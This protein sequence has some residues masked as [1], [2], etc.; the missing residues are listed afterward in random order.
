MRDLVRRLRG[1]HPIGPIVNG[2]PRYG[3]R[4]FV[5]FRPPVMLEAATALETKD[6]RIA[7]LE[8]TIGRMDRL[9]TAA[10]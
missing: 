6:K 7:E 5:G 8:E 1:E 10:R 2:E 3:W 9:L 4:S